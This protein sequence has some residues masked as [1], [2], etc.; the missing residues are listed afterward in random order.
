MYTHSTPVEYTMD[1]RKL[2]WEISG[3]MH[4]MARRDADLIV[5]IADDYTSLAALTERLWLLGLR[6]LMTEHEQSRQQEGEQ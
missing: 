6:E 4:H 1:E 2:A 3:I 5:K